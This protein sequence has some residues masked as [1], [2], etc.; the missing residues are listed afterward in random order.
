MKQAV[1]WALARQEQY[2][3]QLPPHRRSPTS[4]SATRHLTPTP[5]KSFRY[6]TI[7][8]TRQKPTLQP[9]AHQ[10]GA[11]GHPRTLRQSMGKV[12]G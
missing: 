1:E 11:E 10:V 2:K 12:I 7:C 3:D 6:T 9:S 4:P 8:M 5:R